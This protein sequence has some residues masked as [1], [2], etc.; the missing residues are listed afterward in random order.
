M[1]RMFQDK[2]HLVRM[3]GLFAAGVAVFF[4]LRL[5][6]VPA[7]FG[8]HGHY[9]GGALDDNRARPL[10]YGGHERCEGCHT[11]V[12]EARHQGGHEGV[13]CEACHGPLAA[14]AESPGDVRP[15]RP[16]PQRI[17]LTCHLANAGK[18]RGFPQVS[19]PDHA[20]AGAC[21]DC[22]VP[23]APRLSQSNGGGE[24]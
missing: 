6:L 11:D 16:D 7:D 2:E 5:A 14:H 4:V 12:V 24:R 15:A 3:A 8:K 13:R 17:C 18:P 10:V 21:G 1:R 23:H 19:V 9:R 22:H 20:E